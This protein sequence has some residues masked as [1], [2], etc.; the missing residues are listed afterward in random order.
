MSDATDPLASNYS[1][2]S[3]RDLIA[4]VTSLRSNLIERPEEW[5]N[6]TL[7]RFLDAMAAWLSAFPQSYVNTDHAVPDPDWRFVA[8]V[9][10]AA[11]VY[12]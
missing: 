8:D 11:R 6:G 2:E 9:L 10:R 12:E 7:E 1:V 4:V 3:T 5:E